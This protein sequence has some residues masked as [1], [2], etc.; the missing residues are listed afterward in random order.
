M[1]ILVTGASRGIGECIAKN[2]DGTIFAVGRN[3]EKLKQYEYLQRSRQNEHAGDRKNY[4]SK[5]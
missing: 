3:E 1:N 2:L 5:P 4:Q